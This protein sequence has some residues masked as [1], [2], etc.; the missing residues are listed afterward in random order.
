MR[1]AFAR[2]RDAHGRSSYELVA[3]HVAPGQ[4]VLELGCGDGYLLTLAQEHGAR[5]LG[6]ELARAEAGFAQQ[7][8]AKV[9]VADAAKLPLAAASVE[10][11][12]SH[13]AL[14]VMAALD[15]VCDEVDRV[16]VP[17][18]RLVAMLGGG[19][20]LG[21]QPHGFDVLL[22]LLDERLRGRARAALGDRRAADP[23][24]FCGLWQARGYRVRWQRCELDFG[25]SVGQVWASLG[26]CYDVARLTPHEAR[27]LA[28]AFSRE[29]ARRFGARV[30]ATMVAFLAQADKPAAQKPAAS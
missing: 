4:R 8:G 14:S 6:L 15:A 30:P 12:L 3:Q 26:A 17:G 22:S 1:R 28:A 29:C 27:S 21:E 24:R 16:L 2:G 9:V 7:R 23:E 25:G 18:G 11:V 13:F 10:V 20:A 19:P 5:G